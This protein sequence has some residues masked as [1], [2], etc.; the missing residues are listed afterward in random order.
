MN[1]KPKSAKPYKPII[2]FGFTRCRVFGI[3]DESYNPLDH[4]TPH[5]TI[6]W[7]IIEKEVN[8]NNE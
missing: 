1:D 5:H 2:L 8:H 7:P 4:I 6:P 3:D